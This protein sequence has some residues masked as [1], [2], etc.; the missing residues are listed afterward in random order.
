[1]QQQVLRT[2]EM[3]EHIKKIVAALGY[4]QRALLG[5][6]FDGSEDS[7]LECGLIVENTIGLLIGQV[8]KMNNNYSFGG[9][10]K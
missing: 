9:N 8:E 7:M 10:K 4:A 5:L 6:H 1:M 3:E 2:N